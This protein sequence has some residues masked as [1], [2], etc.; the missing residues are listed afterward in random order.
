M[1]G[2]SFQK[3]LEFNLRVDGETWH[4][5]DSVSGVLLVK[6]HGT[7]ATSLQ[8]IHL[9]L[10]LGELKKVRAKSTDAFTVLN[11]K[12]IGTG[13][14]LLPQRELSFPWTF[15]TDRNFPI[16]DS[17]KSP[18]LLYGHG[19]GIEKLAQLQINVQP[20]WLI[21]EFLK[22]LQTHFRFVVKS[23]KSNKG[24]VEVKLVPPDSKKFAKLE[25]LTL[26][27]KFEAESMAVQY[28]F[29]VKKIEASAA[30]VNVKKQKEEAEQVFSPDQYLIPSGRLN[31]ELLET[32]VQ[33]ALDLVESKFVS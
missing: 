21:Q 24:K 29:Q 10:A 11:S 16:T 2:T 33:E 7:E 15:E 5:G 1:K 13:E 17:T 18:F 9:H 30:S 19:E 20:Y 32:A 27:I 31:H 22:I 25:Q 14:E 8:E 3:P 6:N 12:P 23:Q 4:Q 26:Q 28:I